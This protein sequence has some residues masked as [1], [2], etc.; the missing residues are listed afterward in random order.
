MSEGDLRRGAIAGDIDKV[1]SC[2]RRGANIESKNG[3]GYTALMLAAKWGYPEI[4]TLLLENKANV[5]ATDNFGYTAL[6]R[7]AENGHKPVVALLLENKADIDAADSKGRKAIDYAETESM[8]AV[9][10]KHM[11]QKKATAAAAAA[12]AAVEMAA[13]EALKPLYKALTAE[14]YDEYE[15]WR[16]LAPIRRKQDALII[17]TACALKEKRFTELKVLKAQKIALTH[18]SLEAS[19][20]EV[21]MRL[22]RMLVQ[23]G[24]RYEKFA[25]EEEFDSCEICEQYQIKVQDLL[26]SYFP[27][28]DVSPALT[29]DDISI[30]KLHMS[31]SEP[32]LT[33]VVSTINTSTRS[34]GDTVLLQQCISDGKS[35]S[36]NSWIL[37]GMMTD[38]TT[39]VTKRR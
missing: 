6:M 29:T 21:R 5:N 35:S 36:K 28:I 2:L 33:S 15:T 34:S 12:A 39:G 3:D 20:P 19:S 22:N 38:A 13:A 18:S 37:E 27:V 30:D 10:Q 23:F 14:L 32:V 16:T 7:A 25:D 1:T 26:N 11:E 31:A 24:N 17:S 8:K 4:V 9:F